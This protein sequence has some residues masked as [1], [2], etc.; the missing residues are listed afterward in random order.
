MDKIFITGTNRGIGLA[1]VKKYLETTDA[2]IFGTCRQPENA[3]ELQALKKKFPNRLHIIQLDVTKQDS[4]A[5]AVDTVRSVSPV[6]DVIINNAGVNPDDRGRQRLDRIT[7]DLM[8]QVFEVNVIAPVMI[9]QALLPLISPSK[10]GRIANLSSSMGSIEEA[11]Y[12]GYYAYSTS[13][14]AVNMISRMM[15][16]DLSSHITI[17]LDP[18]WVQ[19]DMGGPSATLRPNESATGIIKLMNSLKPKD[20][21]S[22]LRW[23]GDTLPW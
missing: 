17:A 11:D 8:R 7:P 23:N 5:S 15:S 19:T 21:G 1:L 4:I 16:N 22:Y 9:V 20:N 3:D 6:I 14:A 10:N 2:I 12:G 18:G 13:K